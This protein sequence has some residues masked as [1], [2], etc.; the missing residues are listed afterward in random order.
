MYHNLLYFIA[1]QDS[2][3]RPGPNRGGIMFGACKS[4]RAA[5]AIV[6]HLN[7]NPPVV[8]RTHCVSIRRS[9]HFTGPWLD[10]IAGGLPLESRD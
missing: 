6:E 1:F 4:A 7:D 9:V 8:G 2:H 5:V 3:N 10:H